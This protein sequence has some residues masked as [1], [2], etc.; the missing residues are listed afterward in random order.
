MDRE[1]NQVNVACSES[2]SV[3]V[4]PE[5]GVD[6]AIN[7]LDSVDLKVSSLKTKVKESSHEFNI[8]TASL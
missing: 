7:V 5:L 8:N 2:T 3:L 6:D 1:L 4:E